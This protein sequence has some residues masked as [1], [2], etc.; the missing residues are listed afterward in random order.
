MRSSSKIGKAALVLVLA[1]FGGVAFAGECKRDQ[2]ELISHEL[3]TK[4]NL[5]CIAYSDDGVVMS[6]YRLGALEVPLA[7]NMKFLDVDDI[8]EES[9]RLEPSGDGF[10]IYLEYPKNIY[11]VEFG[12]DA[13]SV[14]GSFTQ[15][16]LNAV[17]ASS[18]PQHMNL[19]LN[20]SVMA[21]LRFETLTISQ[22]FDQSVLHL[23]HPL[24]ARITAQKSN[25][26]PS[27]NATSL[28][29]QY[30]TLGD[31][32]EIND[33]HNGWVKISCRANENQVEGWIPLVDVL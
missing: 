17:E 21:G 27:P 2:G 18:P 19:V 26:S 3:K 15:I 14:S 32:V 1:M 12:L 22:I 30:L 16:K 25:V 31:K 23:G 13:S 11:V 10:K 8:A 29:A 4:S 28:P 24:S 7:R 9:V 33:F 5:I 20:A 6:I